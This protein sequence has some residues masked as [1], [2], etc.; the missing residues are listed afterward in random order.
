MVIRFEFV[1]IE[2]PVNS[3]IMKAIMGK[4]EKL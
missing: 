4:G 1:N 2:I 3:V